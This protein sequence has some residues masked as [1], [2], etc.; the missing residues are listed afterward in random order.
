MFPTPRN[1]DTRQA[2]AAHKDPFKVENIAPGPLHGRAHL[3]GVEA[4]VR[5]P[6]YLCRHWHLTAVGTE[7]GR[8]RTTWRPVYSFTAAVAHM[9]R[10]Q[11]RQTI[12]DALTQTRPEGR[13]A[14]YNAGFDEA[15]SA[16]IRI[17]V[18]RSHTH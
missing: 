10:G 2:V 16:A 17:L 11:E 13:S 3:R 12:L 9:A 14:E 15:I 7:H 1:F 8:R 6:V 5:R 18:E 4:G